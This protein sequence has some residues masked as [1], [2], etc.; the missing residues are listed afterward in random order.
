M[1]DDRDYKLDLSESAQEPIAQPPRAAAP[2]TSRPFIS[3]HFAC[4]NIY[5]RIYR[6]ADGKAYQGRCPR[7]AATVNFP[8]GAG[9]TNARFFRVE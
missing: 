3:V 5:M 1:R 6:D 8:V 9:G 4:C 7:C 2:A